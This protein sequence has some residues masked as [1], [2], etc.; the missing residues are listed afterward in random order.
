MLN[1][2]SRSSIPKK[3]KR[4]P[5]KSIGTRLFAA[6]IGGA[7]VGLGGT[8]YLFYKNLE[9]QTV[10]KI[11]QTVDLE[12][13]EIVTELQAVSQASRNLAATIEFFE[14]KGVKDTQ[15]YESLLLEFYK[16]RAKFAMAAYFGQTPYG[17][18]TSKEWYFPYFYIDQKNETQIGTRLSA[19]NNDVIYSELFKDDN[20]PSRDYYKVPV[21]KKTPTWVEPFP[22]Y[23]ITAT[24]FTWPIFDRDGKMIGFSGSDVN[25][26]SISKKISPTV[27]N[28]S[29]YFALISEQGKL[30]SYSPNPQKALDMASYDTIPELKAIWTQIG[31]KKAGIIQA[32]G[33]YWSFRRIETNNWLMLA[34]VPQSVVQMPIL[35]IT[36]A[37]TLSAGLILAGTVFLFVR[38]LNKKLDPILAQCENLGEFDLELK[39]AIRQNDEIDG[40]S[41]SVFEL[42]RQL[43]DEKERVRQEAES[44]L[45]EVQE[46]LNLSQ[47]VEKEGEILQTEIGKIL[48]VVATLES[49]DFT[50]KAEVGE[51]VTGLVANSLN[52][53]VEEI[54]NTLITVS[55]AAEQVSNSAELLGVLAEEVATNTARQAQGA[56][57][58][59]NLTESVNNSAKD[60]TQQLEEMDVKLNRVNKAVE[61]G[62]AEIRVMGL[63]ISSLQ[64]GKDQMLQQMLALG[65]FVGIAEQFVGEQTQI[66][67]LSQTLAMSANL[68]AA[69]ASE[70]KDPRQFLS[71]ARE[72]GTISAQMKTLAQQT[73][74]GLTTLQKRT[75]TVRSVVGTVSQEI[76]NMA[77]LVENFTYG[78]DLSQQV[79]DR[80][81][82]AAGELIQTEESIV[83]STQNIAT[84]AQSSAKTM[85]EIAVLASQTAH[86]TQ[87]TNEQSEAM[88]KLSSNLIQALSLFEL[89]ERL[90]SD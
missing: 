62:E 9:T 60:S 76:E 18:I 75:D 64:K 15:F 61:E 87:T 21:A 10:G 55:T 89:P 40:L 71:V 33:Q 35:G 2:D 38:R 74:G 63:A 34:A 44:R 25:I 28:N 82:Q 73:N 70:Q 8:A 50:T 81:R 19:P 59:M 46:R 67:T 30:L 54:A 45:A 14:R 36:L 47:Q 77:S 39:E 85:K 49:G 24:A 11:Q 86:L 66:A 7:I 72:F 37:G 52:L 31:N 27:L 12:T 3:Q 78:V 48:D 57:M 17:I 26:T 23:G 80:V 90:V 41:I 79:F 43:N 42:I 53:F 29:G 20:Y 5:L 84:A 13:Q 16:T 6:I 58:A 68:L 56:E 88:K 69:R 22:W 4:S 51:G 32:N 65:E 1:S 83:S